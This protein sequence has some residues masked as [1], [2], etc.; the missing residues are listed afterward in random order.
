MMED[1][2]GQVAA[3]RR[4]FKEQQ[5]EAE[6]TEARCKWT[7][8]N[9]MQVALTAAAAT[10]A[11]LGDRRSPSPARRD[12]G[13]GAMPNLSNPEVADV[14]N[15]AVAA[16]RAG[17][18]GPQ[19]LPQNLLPGQAAPGTP[20]GMS[21]DTWPAG[22][23]QASQ[24]Q[25]GQA[26][27]GMRMRSPTGQPNRAQ[28]HGQ[29]RSP[30]G[31]PQ[32]PQS[33]PASGLPRSPGPAPGM[34]GSNFQPRAR[35]SLPTQVDGSSPLEEP[36]AVGMRAGVPDLMSAQPRH[37]APCAPQMGQQPA[38]WQGAGVPGVAGMAARPSMPARQAPGMGFTA[39]NRMG[40]GLPRR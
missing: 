31:Q 33:Q 16:A 13:P 22:Q 9:S 7:E 21:R 15:Q 27:A 28:M 37:S 32:A 8:E 12:G 23:G 38:G 3:L 20:A 40:Q 39:T 1:L 5:G 26:N 18:P 2:K 6:V 11:L 34:A 36:S 30:T 4:L 14:V 29:S 19:G 24:G 25:L 35:P 17:I 10:A